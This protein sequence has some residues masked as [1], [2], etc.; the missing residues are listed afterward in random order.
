MA[1]PG[2]RNLGVT[3]PTDFF[4][5]HVDLRP[6]MMYLLGLRDDYQHD[7][8][9]IA[10][11]IDPNI[12]PASVHAHSETLL[13]LG[14]VY[15]QIDAPFGA[16]SQSALVVSNFALQSNS[17]GDT[18]YTNLENEIASWTATRDP[19]V[20]QMKQMLEGAAFGNLSINEQQAKQ[21]I[22]AA[23]AL[24][25]QASACAANPGGCAQ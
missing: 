16:L 14:Q 6:T 25:D 1:G 15:K 19:L 8:R 13:R 17:D 22:S 5:D 18:V 21:L 7:G 10:E 23:Q 9:V 12:L 3:K 20:A 4:S 11:M 24:L 2:V